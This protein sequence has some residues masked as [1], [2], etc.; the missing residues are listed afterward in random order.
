MND[1]RWLREIADDD[2]V[3][4]LFT[5]AGD[6]LLRAIEVCIELAGR[7]SAVERRLIELLELAVDEGLDDSSGAV[8]IALVLGEIQSRPAVPVLVRALAASDETLAEAGIDA[9]KR[10]GE[11][12]FDALMQALDGAEEPEF[13]HAAY[14]AI[15]GVATW[16]HPYMLDEVRDFLLDRVRQPA[17][18]ARSIEDAAL[19]LARLGDRRALPVLKKILGNRFKGLNPALQDAIEMLQENND[20]VPLASA[21]I[22]WQERVRWLAGD[23]F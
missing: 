18:G 13:E 22:P 23:A 20:G 15:E 9:I 14:Q 6:D 16:E 7:R 19:V 2:E 5:A 12:A 1:D 10:I 17:I 21:A 4:L 11:P 8:W 3:S